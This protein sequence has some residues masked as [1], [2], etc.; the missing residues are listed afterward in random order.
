MNRYRSLKI[1][2]VKEFDVVLLFTAIVISIIG[3]VTVFSAVYSG[4][5]ND[6]NLW[7]SQA[8]RLFVALVGMLAALIIDYRVWH[9]FSYIFYGLGFVVLAV[10]LAIPESG[11]RRWFLGGAIQP[12]ELARII[13][14]IA[15]AKCLSDK[16]QVV[17]QFKVFVVAL[18]MVLA[19][20]FLIFMQP[21]LGY[22]LTLIPISLV[23][24]YVGGISGTYL[25]LVI[26]PGAVSAITT[27]LILHKNWSLV[28]STSLAKAMVLTAIYVGCSSLA[29]YLIS[30]TRVRDG[31]KWVKLVSLCA[32]IGIL[33]ALVGCAV[34]KDYQKARLIAFLDP[35]S[36]PSSSGYHIIQS[37]IAIG[38]G[39]LIGQGYLHGTQ[40]RLDFLPAQHTDFIFSV[41][42]E[43]WGFLGAMV[44]LALYF[45][46]IMNGLKAAARADDTFGT[47]LATG[48]V[49]MI[50]TQVFLNIGVTI[51]L[52]PVT[53]IPLPLMSYGGSS[54]FTTFISIGLL[55]NVRL[56]RV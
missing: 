31:T 15:L 27:M 35:D 12:S 21:S 41:A 9:G 16:K 39:G 6:D 8:I 54:L 3:I 52:M 46:L 32:F 14:I 50:A 1:P 11:A 48:I 51:G 37:K 49:A 13:L 47:L 4:L 29:Y 18:V 44:I 42:A 38:S 24:F 20:T 2:R 34:L 22:A 10:V 25:L 26:I 5:E 53:G 30:K 56:K 28:S 45:T 43:E 40:N 19:Y 23:M 36:Y 55:L 17:S 7:K 33:V